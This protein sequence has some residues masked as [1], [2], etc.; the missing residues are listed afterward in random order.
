M[1]TRRAGFATTVGSS[2]LA[3]FLSSACLAGEDPAIVE[4]KL[5]SAA[6]DAAVVTRCE[7][8]RADG[9]PCR[10]L[11]L[12]ARLK[13]EQIGASAGWVNDVWGWTDRDTGV[14]W[15]LVGHS[16]GTSFVNLK[17]PLEPVYVGI[18]PK[19]EDARPALWRDIKVYDDHAFV[20]ADRAGSHGMQVFD[21]TR[22]RDVDDPPE[23]FSPTATYDRIESAHNVVINEE[24]GFAYTVGTRGGDDT[25]GGGLHMIDITTPA[26]PE[27]AGC[28]AHKRTGRRGTGYTHDAI[29]VVYRGPD[30]EHRGREVCFGSN[31]TRLSIADVSDKDDPVAL[32]SASYPDVG[33]A[34]Q[35]W[36]DEQH[37]FLYMNDEF[38][39]FGD[40]SKT[41]T[42][43]WDVKDLDDPVVVEE[44][45][46]ETESSDHNLYVAG[47]FMFQ[48]NY[49]AGLRILGIADREDP[50]EVAF[51]DTEPEGSNGPSLFGSWSNYPFFASGV[52]VV[53]SMGNGVF[54]L[55]RS[56][57]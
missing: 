51:F 47:D 23:T 40:Q 17:A 7:D 52:I 4:E 10:G 34:H 53:T 29:C 14:E 56:E 27:F 3:A 24:T 42:L 37:E 15:A 54:I 22:L 39:E 11:D 8:G 41:R 25:C 44:F 26:Q 13:R 12:L 43:V 50:V 49:R 20:V 30:T 18:L 55:K 5:D 36:L 33:Y 2:L 16:S 32:A 28:F 1:R 19:P 35:G 31:E 38:D 21:L 46:H 9:F 57:D 48:S 45:L 6:S